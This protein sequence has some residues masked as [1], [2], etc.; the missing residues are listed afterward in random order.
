MPHLDKSLLVRLAPV[1]AL[2]ALTALAL[3]SQ[4]GLAQSTPPTGPQVGTFGFDTSGMD[5]TV[6]P[7]DDFYKYANGAWDART[8]IP[9][10]LARAGAFQDLVEQSRLE[11]RSVVEA[12]AADANAT[13]AGKLVGDMFASFMDEQRIEAAGV[14]PLRADLDRIAGLRTLSDLAAAFG[15]LSR[16]MAFVQGGRLTALAP[17]RLNVAPDANDPDV[18]RASV[19]QGALGLPDRDYYLKLDNAGF[20]KART[21]SSR[22]KPQWRRR[23]GAASSCAIATRRT[24]R[25]PLPTCRN[26]IPD[27]TGRHS[28]LP[29]G[30]VGRPRSTSARR[31]PCVRWWP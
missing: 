5:R 18:M 17:I 15:W 2:A 6:D 20:A 14:A 29:A 19:N 24:I 31:M 4:P 3:S 28:W 22:S 27:S 8:Q 23:C 16:S 12:A 30:W 13:G 7:G 25:P 9:P 26:V 1:T 10:D 21:M 11:T